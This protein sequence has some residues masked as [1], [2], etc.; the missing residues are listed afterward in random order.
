MKRKTFIPALG[1]GRNSPTSLVML[2]CISLSS[3]NIL[4]IKFLHLLYR[5][6]AGVI[7][8]SI[9]YIYA[10]VAKCIEKLYH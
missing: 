1:K 5:I 7:S 9:P 4:I 2:E 8:C 10:E 3:V 6:V